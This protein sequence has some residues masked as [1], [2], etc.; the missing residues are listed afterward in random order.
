MMTTPE[1]DDARA[2]AQAR[3]RAL[4][5]EASFLVQA[6]AG[7]GKT[8]LLIQRVLALLAHVDRPEQIL[9]MTFT[10][11]AAAEMRERV[12]RALRDAHDDASID[13]ANAHELRTR[14]LAT[15]A[16]ARDSRCEWH[17]LDNPSRLRMMT[18]DALATA[19][20]RQAPIT[21]G[22]GALPAFVDA[23]AGLYR[24]AVLAAL[25][26]AASDDPAWCPFLAHLDNDAGTAVDLLAAMLGKRDQWRGRLPVGAVGAEVRG[27]FEVGL[28]HET[29]A[30]L[31]RLA[32]LLPG[33]MN[34]ELAV[35][36]RFAAANLAV[37]GHADRVTALTVAADSGGFPPACSDT[38]EQWQVIANWL[39]VKGEARVRV[40]WNK[41]A[42]FPAGDKSDEGRIRAK[43]KAAIET[44]SQ[45]AAAVPGFA[46]ALHAVRT[47]PPARYSDEAWTFVAATLAL[48][49]TLAAQLQV[50]FA[51]TG[52]TDFIE[53]TLR[54]LTAL[55]DAD[56]PG[57]L[58]LAADLS[59][60]HVLV[61][62][63]QDTSWTH[64]EL[65]AR[66]TAGWSPG[67]GRTL[68]AVGDP[69]QSIYRF[70][71]AEV[72][73]FLDAQA[74][75]R[76]N[77]IAVQCLRL[78]RNFRSDR[79]VV[80]WINNVFPTV[81]GTAGDPARGVVAY[82][83]VL[84]T[85]EGEGDSTPTVELVVDANAEAARVVH[86]VRA[87]QR[88]GAGDIAILVRS[89]AHLAMIL[90][91]L[92][93]AAIPFA[94][95]DLEVLSERLATRDLLTLTRA[96]TQPADAVAGLA[97]LR[98]PWCG[99]TLADLLPIADV[100]RT[101]T[102]L[103]AIHADAVH[104]RL[105]PDG[106][107]RLARLRA[108][109]APALAARGRM[110]LHEVVRAAWLALG[111]P[112][113]GEGEVDIGGAA[114]YFDTL[115]AHARG[116]DLPDWDAFAD[117][118]A[119]LY[120]DPAPVASGAVQV[121]T[122]HKAKGLE[123]DTVI[124]PG[125]AR[126]TR[127]S[128]NPPLRWRLREQAGGAK[129]LLLAPL[130]ART[131]A[132]SSPDPV[133]EYLKSIDADEES[134]ELGRLMYVGCTRARRRLHLLASPKVRVDT[135]SGTRSWG[136]PPSGTAFGRLWPAV[137]SLALPAEPPALISQSEDVDVPEAP[138]L[139]RL[140]LVWRAEAPPPALV[141]APQRV[142]VDLDAVPF[143][144]AQATAASIGTVAHRMLAEIARDGL[145]AWTSEHVSAC[146]A[147]VD[148]ALAAEGVPGHAR[149]DATARVLA[150]LQ[151]TL[152]DPR[153][154]WLFEATH[155]DARSEWA[156][157]G[158]RD[159]IVEHVTL[160]RTF[161]VDGV[162]WIVDF[163]TG[164]HEGGDTDAFLDREEVRY[165]AQLENY[166]RIMRGLDPRPIRL[167]LYYPLVDGGW[168]EWC[169]DAA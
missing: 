15:A 77:D 82:A 32:T 109:L 83:P 118:A 131:G 64:L 120:A 39:L 6:P 11:K 128:D 46:L 159:G 45:D 48:L 68:F 61:D 70:R 107:A 135:K 123:F 66:L 161:V 72:R 160:D 162:R 41:N 145:R 76:I 36:T 65:V 55:G 116:G 43:A 140:P 81:L 9:A 87:A 165:R 166:A 35:H 42:G 17:L 79:P 98:A 103:A 44:W 88:A 122:L 167:A 27:A 12:L 152:D 119:R 163:K 93:R 80:E 138:P 26:D 113:C 62:E 63:F 21:T 84:A 4:D 7:S 75:G 164:R 105:S 168:R 100:A 146:R 125:L 99:L 86:L 115:A 153:G 94:A 19:F 147:R 130:R 111:G 139:R 20:A 54:A 67:D 129:V 149:D 73:I 104:A 148:V 30:A 158:L 31:A 142:K 1:H 101:D 132:S 28:Q 34:G 57:E 144:W 78:T 58:L 151:R 155:A 143:D 91:V 114:R 29:D 95:I 37:E 110:P 137:A 150:V 33:S 47:L 97:L 50:V 102:V 10:R 106:Q 71:E 134:A 154:R 3:S 56:A 89:R 74:S 23:A 124:L 5:V 52:E 49:P 18:I 157:A 38:L 8:G 14:A 136:D 16:L 25:R 24:E 85:R 2:D 169:C 126:P 121:M 156:L 127:G 60:A 69:M 53:A 133:Y 40:Q 51:R 13:P 117:V 96:I 112:A 141:H 59:L 90:P 92:R 22:L 108:A